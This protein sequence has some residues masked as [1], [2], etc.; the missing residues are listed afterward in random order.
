MSSLPRFVG[1]FDGHA[2]EAAGIVRCNAPVCLEQIV[3]RTI[4]WFWRLC[5]SGMHCLKEG[6]HYHRI[7]LSVSTTLNF[8]Y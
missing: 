3:G 2:M 1:T 4:L 6:G 7:E 5:R 8:L